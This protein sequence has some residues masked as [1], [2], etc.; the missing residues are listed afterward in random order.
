MERSG[1]DLERENEELRGLLRRHGEAVRKLGVWWGGTR[2]VM[3]AEEA[4]EV[5]NLLG[6]LVGYADL[7]EGMVSRRGHLGER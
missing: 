2:A 1:R 5:A 6:I 4:H 3:S 7:Y